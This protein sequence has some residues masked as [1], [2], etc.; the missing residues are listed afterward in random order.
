MHSAWQKMSGA[1][2]VRQLRWPASLSVALALVLPFLFFSSNSVM[3]F[4]GLATGIWVSLSSLLEPLH[5]AFSTAAVRL[6]RAQW[7]MCIAHLGVGLFIIAATVTSGYSVETDVAARVGQNWQLAGYEVSFRDLRQVDGPNFTADEGEFEL[8]HD[9]EFVTTLR[10]QRRVY[11]VRTNPMTESAIDGGV[12]R[13]LFIALS[14]PVGDGAW[15]V[16]ARY[17][18]LVRFI[19]ISCIVMALGGLLAATDSRYRRPQ[20][21]RVPAQ[22][23]VGVPL[24]ESAR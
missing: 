2:L 22:A 20:Q 18:P 8:R 5:R 21:Q 6:S 4:V 12:F 15:A 9:G 3:T 24:G 10:P 7:G 17:K 1:A 13:D 14:D 16:H 19:W 11:R 23:P